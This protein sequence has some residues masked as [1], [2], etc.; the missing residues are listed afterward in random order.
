[1]KKL[2]IIAGLALGLVALFAGCWDDDLDNNPVLDT[3]PTE[4]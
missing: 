2:N 3:A 4:F 1:M